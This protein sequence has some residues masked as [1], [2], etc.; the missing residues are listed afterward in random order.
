MTFIQR[1]KKKI[2]I[3]LIIITVCIFIGTIVIFRQ[4]A[5]NVNI[6]KQEAEE[7]VIEKFGG[8]IIESEIDSEFMKTYYEITIISKDNYEIETVVD[9]KNGE[10]IDVDYD[11]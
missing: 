2:F 9:A 1:H 6:S 4:I 10:I 11:D 5:N 7:I 3:T 8:I